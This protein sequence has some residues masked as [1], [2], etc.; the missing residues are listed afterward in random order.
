MAPPPATAVLGIRDLH[1]RVNNAIS[2]ELRGAVWVR[3]EIGELSERKGHCFITLAEPARDGTESDAALD[4]VIWRQAWN[5]IRRQLFDRGISL[6]KGLTVT[7]RG[8]LRLRDGAGQL[9]LRCT[10]VDADAI[11]GEIAARRVALRRALAA[12]GLL[13]ANGRRPLPAVPLRLGVVASVHSE[14]Y[15]DF[16]AVIEASGY[17]FEL[18]VEPVLVQGVS[19]PPTIAAAFALLGER[20]LDLIVLVRGGG[21]RADLDAFDHD[22]V[23]RAIAAAPVPVWT[24]LG[25]TGDRCLADEMA[26]RS[27]TTPTAC[28]HAL[29]T[30]V[31]VFCADL[32]S[33]SRRL[34]GLAGRRTASA[35]D[36]LR[37]RRRLLAG[38]GAAQ[39]DRHRERTASRATEL[40]RLATTALTGASGTVERSAGRLP[41]A[42]G[43]AV[44]RERDRLGRTARRAR[45]GATRALTDRERELVAH[46]RVMAALDPVRQFER[47]WSLT[48]DGDGR[49]VRSASRLRAGERITSRFVDGERSSV[50]EA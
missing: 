41:R 35:E 49:L 13:E 31:E 11:L 37:A 25:H 7:F 29:V 14:G 46:R 48:F 12:E 18:V 32:A 38:C 28:A 39:L 50:V 8:E 9:Q 22:L 17:R 16:R 33:R 27:H 42:A 21:A 20:D 40:G 4:V 47:G 45:L 44:D 5:R 24:G 15:R 23:A 19:A 3:A 10:E 30:L 26:H 1:R 36:G 6:R 43:V 2:R 34:A